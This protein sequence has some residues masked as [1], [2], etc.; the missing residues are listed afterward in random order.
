MQLLLLKFLITIPRVFIVLFIYLAYTIIILIVFFIIC[1]FIFIFKSFGFDLIRS[2]LLPITTLYPIIIF[3]ILLNLLQ[4]FT[5]FTLLLMLL[6][7]FVAV[8][9]G[10]IRCGCIYL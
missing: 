8:S 5:V 10:I 9:V 7:L 2:H 4:I 3:I 1:L 6:L